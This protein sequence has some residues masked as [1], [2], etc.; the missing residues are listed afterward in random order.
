LKN[1][2]VLIFDDALSAVDTH[3]EER[4]LTNITRERA[5]RTTIIV[6]NRVSTLQEADQ[7]VV[8]ED[9]RVTDRGTH[10]SLVRRSGLYREVYLLQ[11]QEENQAP[12]MN[13]P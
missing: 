4:I 13:H 9:G 11:Q 1:P 10:A 3:T 6:S 8:L 12:E 7:I 5:H 2:P